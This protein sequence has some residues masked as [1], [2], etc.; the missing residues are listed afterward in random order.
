MEDELI[1]QILEDIKLNKLKTYKEIESEKKIIL[2]NLY[3][4]FLYYPINEKNKNESLENLKEY[5]YVIENEINHGDYIKFINEK[6]FYNITLNKGGFV[7]KIDLEENFIEIL[8]NNVFLKIKI[9]DNIFFK[10]ISKDEN[11]KLSIL[12]NL[13]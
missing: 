3:E 4:K 1:R 8:N 10:K 5:K 9:E 6:Y 12:E 13:E 2:D 11:I 7:S